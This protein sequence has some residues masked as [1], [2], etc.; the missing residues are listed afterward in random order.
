M[1]IRHPQLLAIDGELQAT[2]RRARALADRAG[3]ARWQRQP[4]PGQW[5]PSECV[6]HLIATIDAFLPLVDAALDAAPPREA[7]VI[8]RF[9]PGLL[10]R[11]LL[12]VIEPPYRIRTKTSAAFVPPATRTPEVDLSELTHRHTALSARLARADGHFL[13]RLTIVSP[14]DARV[15][16][17][18]FTAFRLLPTHERRHLWQA[19]RALDQMERAST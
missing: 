2:I 8:R 3:P 13:D 16:Y 14:F 18:L 11:A 19:E 10:G 4:S 17:S 7:P 6:Q 5:A 15:R 9:A 12:W 1:T